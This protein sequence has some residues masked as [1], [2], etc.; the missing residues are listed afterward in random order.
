MALETAP[1]LSH[2]TAAWR[3]FLVAAGLK[4]WRSSWDDTASVL[5]VCAAALAGG[6]GQSPPPSACAGRD[7]ETQEE[8]GEQEV[9]SQLL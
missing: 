6:F 5:G 8:K 1:L 2:V 7:P 3:L 4:F 9:C